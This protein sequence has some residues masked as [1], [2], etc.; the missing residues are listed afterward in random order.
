MEFH[1][2]TTYQILSMKIH[3]IQIIRYQ[4]IFCYQTSAQRQEKKVLLHLQRIFI[5]DNLFSKFR[6]F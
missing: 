2:D 4:N 3:S 5:C 1:I 6:Y